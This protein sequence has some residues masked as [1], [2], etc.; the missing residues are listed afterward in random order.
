MACSR[1]KL[2]AA[3]KKK[4]M[5]RKAT[6]GKQ[7]GAAEGESQTECSHFPDAKIVIALMS[8]AVVDA[9]ARAELAQ[10]RG[11]SQQQRERADQCKQF[12]AEPAY[13]VPCS[14]AEL[15]SSLEID[16][17][18]C[19]TGDVDK[20]ALGWTRCRNTDKPNCCGLVWFARRANASPPPVRQMLHSKQRR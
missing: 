8:G 17:R 4:L 19:A 18:L 15:F 12:S 14:L 7:C 20:E 13:D 6:I 5:R 16:K 9:C 3:E 11:R 1:R 10:R 2:R